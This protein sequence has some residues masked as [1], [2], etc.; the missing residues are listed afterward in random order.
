MQNLLTLLARK[1]TESV[2]EREFCNCIIFQCRRVNY[3]ILLSLIVN[4]A[5]TV[6]QW[7][8]IYIVRITILGF[9]GDR[10]AMSRYSGAW[11]MER[12]EKPTL[13]CYSF[14]FFSCVWERLAFIIVMW[15][16][17]VVVSAISVCVCVF[18]AV[19]IVLNNVIDNWAEKCSYS[20]RWLY[21]K[22]SP[23][24][25]VCVSM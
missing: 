15:H 3:S 5:V 8:W 11:M 9:G 24:T 22:L 25:Y 6:S 4:F 2:N 20:V 14:I 18:V 1:K 19:V 23:I 10:K 16:H 7:V 17:V 13:L 21:A 12:E